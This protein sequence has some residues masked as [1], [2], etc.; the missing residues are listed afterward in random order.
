MKKNG[1]MIYELV[2]SFALAFTILLVIFNTSISLNR[3]LS[4]LYVKNKISSKQ[5]ILNKKI[6]DDFTN[7]E[8]KSIASTSKTCNVTYSDDTTTNIAIENTDN[9]KYVMIG[10]EK[11]IFSNDVEIGEIKS[12]YKDSN[13]AYR[14]KIPIKINND[15]IDYGIELY[16]FISAKEWNGP[17]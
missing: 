15:D 12:C 5:I 4:D 6:G 16:N 17:N 7:K 10:N 8:I 9:N 3:R 13:G 1:F 11:I 14:I 2:I